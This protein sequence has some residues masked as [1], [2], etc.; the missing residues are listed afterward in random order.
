MAAL[1][2]SHLSEHSVLHSPRA[3][4]LQAFTIGLRKRLATCSGVSW[5]RGNHLAVVNL[6]G[7]HLRIYRFHEPAA[8]NGAAPRLEL[9]HQM[10]EGVSCPEDV[11][12]SLDGQWVA[13]SHSMSEHFGISIHALDPTTLAPASSGR[14]LRRGWSFHGL[15]FS[16]DSRHLAFTDV[17]EPGYV[18]V[19]RVPSEDCVCRLEN[20]RRPLKPKS[21][22]F[23]PDGRLVV[24]AWTP[25]VLPHRPADLR[26]VIL[27]A[28]PFDM[29]SGTIHP[30]PVAEY[31]GSGPAMEYVEMCTVLPGSPDGTYRILAANQ[32][33][34]VVSEF[35]LDPDRSALTLTGVFLDGLSFPHGIDASADGRFMAV[36]NLGTD[37]L[38]IVRMT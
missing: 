13:I 27:A 10:S 12:V 14:M 2:L 8:T 16:P 21:V 37:T 30:V 36:T 25:N 6:Y 15:R 17:G 5:F 38:C 23:S 28:Y 1:I 18:E 19:V 22:T 11:S 26:A 32:G 24:I 35:N 9:L 4:E 33:A 34:D 31:H 3:K 29:A 7:G 20:P